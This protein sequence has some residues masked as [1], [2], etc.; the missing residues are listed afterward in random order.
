MDT[1]EMSLLMG[2]N[3]SMVDWRGAGI[4]NAQYAGMLGNAMA[5]NV[6]VELIPTL[7]YKS[8]LCTKAELDEMHILRRRS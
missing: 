1:K 3:E 2:F 8:K 6:L 4:T 7:L 5:V